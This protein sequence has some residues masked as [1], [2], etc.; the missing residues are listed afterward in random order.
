[1]GLNEAMART[2]AARAHMLIVEA[3]G[4]FR[5]RV[6]LERAIDA[7]PWCRTET[8][9][10]ADVLAVVGSPG[11]ELTAIIDRT[12]AQLSEPRVRVEIGEEAH[13]ATGLA[14]ARASLLASAAHHTPEP[15]RREGHHTPTAHHAKATHHDSDHSGH[16][17]SGHDEQHEHNGPDGHDEHDHGS[18]SPDGISLAEGAEDRDG[19]EMDEL[20]L[21]LGPV[22]N[23][24]PAGVVLHL[25]LNGDVVTSATA[26]RLDSADESSPARRGPEYAARLLDSA[27]SLL[28]LAGLPAQ[29]ARARL[30]RDRCLTEPSVDP[31][32]VADFASMLG[33]LRVLR[34][35]WR[36]MTVTDDQG[37]TT[38]LHDQLVNLVERAARSL[39][40][41]SAPAAARWP[42][43]DD[44][45]GLVRGQE[46]AAVRLWMAAL[47]CDAFHGADRA[48]TYE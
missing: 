37:R 25:T 12:W 3:P 41:D 39:Q 38:G 14:F 40:G 34:W 47:G 7:T 10:D 43:L 11:A 1:M 2:V 16:D 28:S 30:L 42:S 20:H 8:V 19:L 4:A 6:G 35:L 29:S 33:R 27:A 21:P 18:M 5:T 45:P 15:P 13:I 31:H 23:H 9:A 32:D 17:D 26:E 24:W 44:L 36:K 22:L 48:T 46:L